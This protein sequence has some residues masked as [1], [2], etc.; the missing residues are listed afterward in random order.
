MEADI[1]HSS[2]FNLFTGEVCAAWAHIA[3]GRP[4]ETSRKT[5]ITARLGLGPTRTLKRQR[6][7]SM[8]DLDIELVVP[9]AV[10]HVEHLSPYFFSIL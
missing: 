1:A 3:G 10:K 7:T 9:S 8:G 4:S 2:Q 5:H 6:M